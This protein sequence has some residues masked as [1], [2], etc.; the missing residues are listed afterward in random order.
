MHRIPD[1]RPRVRTSRLVW[2]LFH[3]LASAS[4]GVERQ[5]GPVRNDEGNVV[6]GDVRGNLLQVGIVDGDV[7]LHENSPKVHVVTSRD[8]APVFGAGAKVSVDGITYVVHDHLVAEDFAADGGA[9]HRRARVSSVRGRSS[10]FGWFR[11]VDDRDAVGAGRMLADEHA[12]LCEYFPEASLQFHSDDRTTTLVTRWPGER[13]G[14]PSDSLHQLLG[15]GPGRDHSQA[16]RWCTGLAGLCDSLGALHDRLLAH[17]ALSPVAL[18]ARDDGRIV[19]RDLGLAAQAGRPGENPGEY[20]TPEQRRRGASGPGPWTDVHQVAA[21][22]HLVLTGRVPHPTAPPPLRRWEPVV[23]EEIAT[24]VDAALTS[25]PAGRPDIRS[26]G[27][28]LRLAQHHI[29]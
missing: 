15:D 29:D 20:Q 10:E 7:H 24:V 3:L 11:Q 6:H 18:I 17:R 1:L 19:L 14:R 8:P 28:A 27:A 25:D 9:V 16:S 4:G 13:S 2:G 26:L 23:P 21:I 22:A 5:S 12:L